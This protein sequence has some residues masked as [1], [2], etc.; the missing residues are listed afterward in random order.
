MKPYQLLI[1]D[2]NG[3]LVQDNLLH[4]QCLQDAF[5]KFTWVTVS[6]E[7]VLPLF[8]DK[9]ENIIKQLLVLHHVKGDPREI[10]AYRHQLYYRRVAHH[11]LL[12]PQ[13][14]KM[15]HDLHQHYQMALASGSTH[16]TLDVTLKPNER[17]V[18][19]YL[20]SGDEVKKGKPHPDEFL[21]CAKK[22]QVDPKDCLVIG[23]GL[24]D[25]LAAKAAKM[26]FVGVEGHATPLSVLKKNGAKA[27]FDSVLE[28]EKWLLK[29]EKK[30]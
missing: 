22:L 9:V 13:T 25:A 16:A 1:F 19:D 26:D 28:L 4:F 27:V 30:S 6:K 12:L 11:H 15:L 20:V 24:N 2:L 5:K 10:N 3:T 23:D 18:F 29:Q 17:H 7:D 21:L 8:G 14:K